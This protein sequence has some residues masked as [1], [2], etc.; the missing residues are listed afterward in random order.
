MLITQS[1]CFPQVGNEHKQYDG[2][3]HTSLPRASLGSLPAIVGF[4]ELYDAFDISNE[5]LTVETSSS[6][7][8]SVFTAAFE[9]QNRRTD[10][11]R[12]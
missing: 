9:A 2:E 5:L 12:Q 1:R 6:P 7:C 8:S 3:S 11:N 4:R 10:R